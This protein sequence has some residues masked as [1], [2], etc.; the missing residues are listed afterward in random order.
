MSEEWED[1]PGGRPE[2]ATKLDLVLW[3][4]SRIERSLEHNVLT[5]DEYLIKHGHLT[6][7]VTELEKDAEQAELDKK[8]LGTAVVIALI[9]P[10]GTWAIE[11]LRITGG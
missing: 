11:L 6:D 9:I 5:R 2:G 1:R 4:L 3:R 7:R 8:K 10:V